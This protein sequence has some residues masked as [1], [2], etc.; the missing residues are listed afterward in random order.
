[1]SLVFIRLVSHEFA[2]FNNFLTNRIVYCYYKYYSINVVSLLTVMYTG[3]YVCSLSIARK[4]ERKSIQKE[5][6]TKQI[7]L[8]YLQV[9]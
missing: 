9:M 8:L 6:K 4:K 2:V 7:L 1:M 3:N 5:D